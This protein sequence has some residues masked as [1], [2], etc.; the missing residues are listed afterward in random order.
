MYIVIYSND[1]SDPLAYGPFKSE[2]AANSYAKI[3]RSN[4]TSYDWNHEATLDIVK[5]K[6]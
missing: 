5:L 2:K 6:K 1:S 4:F 3:M